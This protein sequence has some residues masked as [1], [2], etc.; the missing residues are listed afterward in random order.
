[1]AAAFNLAAGAP[2]Q[3]A[4]SGGATSARLGRVGEGDVRL[5]QRRG[6]AGRAAAELDVEH[7]PL[8]R[9]GAAGSHPGE[10]ERRGVPAEGGWKAA[11]RAAVAA[12][13]LGPYLRAQAGQW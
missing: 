10:T 6:P 4:W 7:M 9:S 3:A 12:T 5:D 8:L 1:R 11:A 2:D 13:G